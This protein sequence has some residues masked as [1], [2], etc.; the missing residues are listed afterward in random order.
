MSRKFPIFIANSKVP[1]WLSR[2]AP[3][4]IY[5]IS[6]GVWVWCRYTANTRQRHHE[7]IHYQQQL[8]LGFL[9]QWV[10]YVVFW[11]WGYIKW[12]DGTRAYRLNPFEVEAYDN[13]V[14]PLYLKNRRRYVGWVK[15]VPVLWRPTR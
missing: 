5:A 13:D 6:V 2:L 4:E 14:D 9:L 3:I 7:T 10:L 1:V 12:R 15:H 8:E 11:L